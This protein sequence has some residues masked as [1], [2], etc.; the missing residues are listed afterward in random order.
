MK[1]SLIVIML[2]SLMSCNSKMDKKASD[3]SL[4][5]NSDTTKFNKKK[6]S[7]YS[8]K[9]VDSLIRA[10]VI[11]QEDLPLAPPS[12]NEERERLKKEYDQIKVIDSNFISNND[13][14]HFHLKYYCLKD[15]NLVIP[16]FYDSDEK[17][18]KD[19]VTHP[20]VADISLIRNRVTVLNKQFKAS[21]FDRFF[22]DNF[23][24]NLKKYGSMLE[25]HFLKKNKDKSRVVL[26]C[27]I[28]IPT[29][30][31]GTGMFLIISKNGDYKIVENY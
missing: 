13:T 16:K 23:G 3:S 30:D 9:A 5:S 12:Q 6:S 1:K 19:F 26:A 25:L 24:G 31:I 27:S 22:V 20:F 28:A 29:T 10:G 7:N 17:D 18:Q 8:K 14:L 15:S 11:S 21:D 2:C 4:T